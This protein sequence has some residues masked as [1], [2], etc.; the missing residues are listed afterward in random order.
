MTATVIEATRRIGFTS[1]RNDRGELME[2]NYDLLLVPPA[3]EE[4]AWEVINSRGKVETANNNRNFHYGKYKLA[5]WHR[6]SDANNWFF[7]DSNLCKQFLM[8]WDRVDDGIKQDRDTDTLVAKWYTYERYAT[9][10]LWAAW[11]WVYG[12]NVS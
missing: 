11:Q 7:I 8:W 5:M 3:L 2:V 9:T 6:L 10:G 4:T 12:H 1:I